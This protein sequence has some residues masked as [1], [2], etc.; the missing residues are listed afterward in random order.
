M[1][2]GLL[3]MQ[4]VGS[5]LGGE[6]RFSVD[7]NVANVTAVNHGNECLL[8]FVTAHVEGVT[9]C[10]TEF[11]GTLRLRYETRH[12]DRCGCELWTRY[13]AVQDPSSCAPSP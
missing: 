4:M 2:F 9:L 10:P 13:R 5:F 12:P 3:D 1:S 11:E 7:G 8:D 6:D